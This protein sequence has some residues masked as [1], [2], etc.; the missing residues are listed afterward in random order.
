MTKKVNKNSNKA[1]KKPSCSKNC[2]KQ[3]K[4]PWDAV[5]LAKILNVEPN[6]TKLSV[7]DI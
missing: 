3:L 5:K 2:T 6:P 7:N 1:K 4:V